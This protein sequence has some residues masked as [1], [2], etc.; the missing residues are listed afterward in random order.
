[1]KG[2]RF[3]TTQDLLDAAAQRINEINQIG[4]IYSPTQLPLI[5][6]RII[7]HKGNYIID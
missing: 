5:W 6:E 7:Q 2:R 3:P 4:N 1:L